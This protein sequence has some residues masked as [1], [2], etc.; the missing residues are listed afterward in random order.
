MSAEVKNGYKLTEV[1][2]IPDDWDVTLLGSLVSSLDAGV[3]VNSVETEAGYA[4]DESI[5]KTSCVYG[6]KFY[7]EE[8][9]KILHQDIKRAKLNPRKNSIVISRMNTPALVGECGYIDQDYP[10]LFLP[11]RLWMT[12]HE[13]RRPMCVLWLSYLLSYGSFNRAIKESATGTS[14]SMKNISKGSLFI[15]QVPLP[16]K[17]EQES[18]AEALSDADALIESLEQLIT[19]K[20]QI[21][22]GAMQELLNPLDGWKKVKLGSLGVFLKGSGVKKD[23]SMSGNIPCIRYGE[24]YT[25]HKYYI[26]A[27]DSWISPEV[28]ATAKR[29]KSGDI[30]FAGSGETKEEIGKCVA[31]VGNIEAYAGGDI[32]IFRPN[33]A[34]SLFLGCYL[35]TESVNRQ[36]AS[37]GQGDAVVHI[38]SNALADIDLIIPH[39]DEQAVIASVLFDMDAEIGVLE[40]KLE[41]ALQLKRGMMHNLL[42][43][44]IRLV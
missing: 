3:S 34:N 6:G 11:D 41:K 8:H 16:K 35:N 10:N 19:K 17:V 21:K 42:T 24:I 29:I 40:A 18:I 38:G 28:A 13:G 14:G 27:F 23:E 44:K 2:V 26:K 37:R 20:R 31:F 22:Q 32:V 25:K 39:V 15:L 30:L 7:S 12:R 1:G 33:N 4:H 43:G 9:K 5:L 36:K